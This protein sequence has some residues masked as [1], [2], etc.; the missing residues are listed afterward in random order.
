MSLKD[1]HDAFF[2]LVSPISKYASHIRFPPTKRFCSD[3]ACIDKLGQP[4]VLLS[5]KRGEVGNLF[6]PGY[7]KHAAFLTDDGTVI[8]AVTTGVREIPLKDFVSDKDFVALYSLNF[9]DS[10][11]LKNAFSAARLQ[12]GKPYDFLFSGGVNAFYC[13]ELIS[14]ALQVANPSG[15]WTN[16]KIL[17]EY[18]T[19]PQDFADAKT[20]TTLIF[21]SRSLT[22]A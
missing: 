15:A 10:E 1:L 8:E 17:W 14:Y 5:R 16:R 6:I 7:W 19:Y 20:K 3:L 21:D 9:I 22:H 4:G 12:I 18:T 2:L 13:S 11:R